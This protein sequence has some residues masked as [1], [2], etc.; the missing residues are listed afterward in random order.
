MFSQ[1][2][3]ANLSGSKMLMQT[4]LHSEKFEATEMFN[5]LTLEIFNRVVLAQAHGGKQ[6]LS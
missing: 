4:T 5:H 1:S 3:N 6:Q 2:L